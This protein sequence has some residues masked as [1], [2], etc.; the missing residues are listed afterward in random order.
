MFSSSDIKVLQ[1][2]QVSRWRWC[3]W[4]PFKP[5]RELTE[6]RLSHK[7]PEGIEA[8]TF[9]AKLKSSPLSHNKMT[10]EIISILDVFPRQEEGRRPS[11]PASAPDLGTHE[12]IC[13]PCYRARTAHGNSGLQKAGVKWFPRRTDRRA[14]LIF[15]KDNWLSKENTIIRW[16]CYEDIINS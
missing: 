7:S 2:F 16:V 6:M 3:W 11:P 8:Y 10:K 13:I 15:S 4:L 1:Y 12:N 5:G 9:T 14:S